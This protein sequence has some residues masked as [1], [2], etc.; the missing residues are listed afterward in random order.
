MRR[1][2]VGLGLVSAL[3][4][5]CSPAGSGREATGPTATDS[6][7]G[8]S[9]LAQDDLPGQ[10]RENVPDSTASAQSGGS[11][12]GALTP[13]GPET[14]FGGVRGTALPSGEVRL[15]AIVGRVDTAAGRIVL[16]EPVAGYSTIAVTAATEFRL[17]EGEPGGFGDV[18]VGG[19]ISAT[20]TAGEDALLVAELVVLL[21]A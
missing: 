1:A 4:V 20:G 17:S 5:S 9:R 6:S 18:E 3:L 11:G 15:R 2:V 14:G 12:P 19:P 8:P 21:D 10:A 13:S 16:Q 7:E